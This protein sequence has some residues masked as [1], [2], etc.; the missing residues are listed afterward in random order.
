[1]ADLTKYTV[2][3]LDDSLI[4]LKAVERVLT[5]QSKLCN[6][7]VES[8]HSV[9]PFKE[10]IAA[11]PS[12]DFALVDIH[13]K[14]E[15]TNGV[16]IAAEIVAKYP[17][18]I[19]VIRS[20]DINQTA[21]AASAGVHDYVDKDA[22]ETFL[23]ERLYFN[24]Q[25]RN[26]SV[27]RTQVN[28][29][30]DTIEAIEKDVAKINDSAVRTVHVFGETGCGKEITARLFRPMRTVDCGALSQN[31]LESELFGH[32]KGAFTGA[33]K[34]KKG[35][36]DVC[37]GAW[38]FLDEIG[39]MSLEAQ[40]KLLRAV[41]EKEISPVGSLDTIK[42]DFKLV[43]A[44]NLDLKK[45]A[46]EGLFRED[47]RQRLTEYEIAL[48]PLR[49]RAGEINDLIDY[50]CENLP[51]G[52]YSIETPA[53]KLLCSYDYQ[54]GNIRELRRALVTMTVHKL[55]GN[56]LPYSAV[57]EY[58]ADGVVEMSGI[59]DPEDLFSEIERIKDENHFRNIAVT[60]K[61]KEKW[62]N[63]W[64]RCLLEAIKSSC[65]EE[66]RSYR[67]LAPILGMQRMTLSKRIAEMKNT[68]LLTDGEIKKL[69]RGN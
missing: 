3:H 16:K 55:P 25:S 69:F 41:G 68:G 66:P 20:S 19:V 36:L 58:I 23:A 51:G 32:K 7:E 62:E 11:E 50:F 56:V 18:I 47:L 26:S 38:V 14:N 10:R 44:T 9:A 6:F 46:K 30:G 31:L 8:F 65:K 61:P 21:L 42:V 24:I 49:E 37:N 1:M 12:P 59:C 48:P 57:P 43:T 33:D 2:V 63:Y 64:N 29:V 34:D 35:V 60:W 52:P 40:A 22:D 67:E 54:E 4:E 27:S 15:D 53:R 13:L 39:N 28:I 17:D 45:A 5:R